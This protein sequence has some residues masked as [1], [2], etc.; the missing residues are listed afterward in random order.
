MPKLGLGVLPH[1]GSVQLQNSDVHRKEH[2]PAIDGLREAIV[3]EIEHPLGV[4]D[5]ITG[6]TAPGE[7]KLRPRRGFVPAD[8]VG[9]ERGN[10]EPRS[11]DCKP[12]F[13]R[14][15]LHALKGRRGG[16]SSGDHP[17]KPE[18]ARGEA[19]IVGRAL[20]VIK[21]S[22]LRTRDQTALAAR[23]SIEHGEGR[24]IRGGERSQRRL[25]WE[26]HY[27]KG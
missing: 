1:A 16:A 11:A 13:G 20:S 7:P 24:P 2:G 4:D 9:R 17:P 5:V 26:A 25:P 22:G 15:A 19:S 18:I 8:T 12:R 23:L 10:S 14:D 21:P 6:G 3:L 27:W